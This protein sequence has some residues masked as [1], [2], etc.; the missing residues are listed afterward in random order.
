[1]TFSS[2]P[3]AM[4]DTFMLV[5][6]GGVSA[7]IVGAPVTIM[8]LVLEMSGNFSATVAVLVG[9]LFSTV[10]TRYCFG[11]S[12]STWRFHL[13]GLRIAGAHDIGWINE[14]TM[15]TLMQIIPTCRPARR[16]NQSP[17]GVCLLSAF[18]AGYYPVRQRWWYC[19]ARLP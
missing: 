7:S 5:G 9:I 19:S 18:Q 11:Y 16:E 1:M 4:M 3:S 17:G 14:L 8:L 15:T 13:R 10:V 6:I 12:F 2:S